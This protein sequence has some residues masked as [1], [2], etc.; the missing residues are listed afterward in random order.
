MTGS[1]CPFLVPKHEAEVRLQK[2]GRTG[3]SC[4]SHKTVQRV[5]SS[6]Q[7]SK[8]LYILQDCTALKAWGKSQSLLVIMG[9]ELMVMSNQPSVT[10]IR[11][12]NSALA[13]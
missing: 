11:S 6:L 13:S 1:S 7:G 5:G 10:W 8:R 9:R 2:S 3:R 4:T 12:P